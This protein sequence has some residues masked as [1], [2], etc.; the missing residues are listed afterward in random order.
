MAGILAWLTAEE[1]Y[2]AAQRENLLAQ[3]QL[4]A[5]ALEGNL[6]QSFSPEA[7]SQTTNITPGIHARFLD[8]GGAVVLGVPFPD[9]ESPV[10]VP[11][12]EDPGF[13]A[14]EDLVLREEIQSALNGTATTAIRELDAL[15][16][17]RVLYA[18]APVVDSNN[19]VMSLVYLATPLPARGLPGEQ[20]VRLISAVALAGLLASVI[21][22]VLARRIAR[23]LEDL[24]QAAA[25]VSSGDLDPQ[26]RPG[27]GI[28]ELENLGQTFNSM[29]NNLRHAEKTK[30]AFIADATHELRTPLTVIK[31]TVETLEEGALEDKPGSEKLLRSMSRE[32]NR[33]IRLVNDLLILTRTDSGAFSLNS[34][35]F[36]LEELVLERC[37]S[38]QPLARHKGVTFQV[39]RDQS[40]NGITFG[41]QARTAQVV[42]NLLDNAL[43]YAPQDSEISIVF[44]RE[45][46]QIQCSITDQGPGV[47]A[48][49]LELIF[50]RFYRV[51]KSRDR[52]SGGAG[53]GLAIARSLIEA[54]GGSIK[55]ISSRGS[56]ATFTFSLPMNTDRKLANS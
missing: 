28:K 51:E 31:G 15:D 8:E 23:P 41:D 21:G 17:K 19:Q 10:Q 35:E 45:N 20:S 32:T 6:P 52:E 3:A 14:A 48:D 36:N 54:Q 53:L 12:G 9:G 13:V 2:L 24:D 46:D 38:F 56:G 16:G 39:S 5:A 34:A 11:P 27:S 22:L 55:A 50:E 43:R 7:Y 42:D 40:S 47:P 44:R 26:I 33:L 30:T 1:I 29:T 37:K 4:T 25:A 18:A 49:Q